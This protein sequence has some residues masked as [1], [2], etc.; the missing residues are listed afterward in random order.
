MKIT[1]FDDMSVSLFRQEGEC[2]FDNN[3]IFEECGYMGL[4][5]EKSVEGLEVLQL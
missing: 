3:H 5:P 2:L 1:F 4:C